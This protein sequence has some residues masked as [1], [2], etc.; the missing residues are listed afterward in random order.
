MWHFF[1][2]D[3]QV[4]HVSFIIILAQVSRQYPAKS[5]SYKSGCFLILSKG[6][7]RAPSRR[8]KYWN[9]DI[10]RR[11]NYPLSYRGSSHAAK[12]ITWPL[13]Y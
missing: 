2:H 6:Y 13:L 7:S 11:N 8:L 4:N 10:S 9:D 1:F 12:K 5:V 3:L